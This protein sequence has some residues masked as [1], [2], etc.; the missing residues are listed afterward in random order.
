M[1]LASV[2]WKNQDTTHIQDMLSLPTSYLA[3]DPDDLKPDS[4]VVL[5][6]GE[7]ISPSFY[8]QKSVMAHADDVPSKRDAAEAAIAKRAIEMGLP[9]LGICRGAQLMC[10]LLGGKLW[11][12]VDNHAGQSHPL[13][14][15]GGYY[16]TNSYHHQMMVPTD[17]MD[18]LG[19]AYNR[20]KI[21]WGEEACIDEGDEPEIVFHKATS[22]LLIQ[23]HP[24]WTSPTDDLYV[25]TRDLVKEK[26]NVV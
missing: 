7:D 8:N 22:S 17:D 4:L 3:T 2:W 15:K 21:K 10:A 9:I 20:S 5:W 12:H 6:G 13:I 26:L 19:Y 25:L 18:I 23:G 24:E 14:Y 1:K 16:S 11:Q